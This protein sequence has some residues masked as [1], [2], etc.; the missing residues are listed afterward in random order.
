MDT[1]PRRLLAVILAAAVLGG[2][3]AC[4]VHVGSDGFSMD[5]AAGQ[6]RDTW[7]RSY[8]LAPGGRLELINVNGTISAE[9]A[10]G[11]TVELVGD[12][13]AKATSDQAAKELLEKIE[14]REE[15]SDS[16]VRVEVRVPR[17]F[18][19]GADVKWTVKIPRGV[20]ADL[21]TVNGRVTLSGLEGDIYARTVN[22]GVMGKGLA[23]AT[24]EASTVNGGVDV[25][26]AAPLSGDGSVALE[27]VNG[28]VVLALP[29]SSRASVTARVTNGGINTGS[30]GFQVSGEQ[31]RRRFEGSLNGGGTRVTLETTNGGVRI[32]KTA[33]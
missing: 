33:G 30:L 28:G 32:S 10:E 5:L 13:T 29:E 3:A 25:E 23:V 12:R 1:M 15:T 19:A 20:V 16:R 24:L 27:S 18:A 6:A 7:T 26:L 22:G 31:T 8:N 2:T 9:P 17:T 14:M 4:D 21:R 11:S